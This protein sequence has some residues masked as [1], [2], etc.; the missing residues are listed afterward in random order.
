MTISLSILFIKI[1]KISSLFIHKFL[2]VSTLLFAKILP[3]H[4]RF[5]VTFATEATTWNI[6]EF[7]NLRYIMSDGKFFRWQKWQAFTV[8]YSAKYL[9]WV[10][11]PKFLKNISEISHFSKVTHYR[12]I[13]GGR[14]SLS[15]FKDFNCKSAAYFVEHLFFRSANFIFSLFFGQ[16]LSF[17]NLCVHVRINVRFPQNLNK[18]SVFYLFVIRIKSLCR[19]SL[20]SRKTSLDRK[21]LIGWRI[22]LKNIFCEFCEKVKNSYLEDT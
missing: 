16:E 13:G 6:K 18:F 7:L 9:F 14:T 1:F 17:V 10:T 19:R 8:N 12:R 22:S 20:T 5:A 21:S 3:C 15:P 11:W 4:I 2:F